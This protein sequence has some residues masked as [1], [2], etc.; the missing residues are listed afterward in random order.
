MTPRTLPEK[1]IKS[2]RNNKK[3]DGCI[4]KIPKKGNVT[5]SIYVYCRK[6]L[7][8]FGFDKTRNGQRFMDGFGGKIE[9]DESKIQGTFLN[10]FF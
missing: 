2:A 3:E 9:P 7:D 10:D 4:K 8:S 1:K 5:K 6:Q